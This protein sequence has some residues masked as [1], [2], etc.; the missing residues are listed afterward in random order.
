MNR[1]TVDLSDYPD[2]VVIYLGMR[3]NQFRGLATLL[4]FGPRIHAAVKSN[5]D[6][7]LAHENVVYSLFPLHVGMRQYWRD[8]E[9]LEAWARADPHRQWW[10]AFLRD[11]KGTG[12]WH[13]AYFRQGGMEAVYVNMPA[14]TGLRRFASSVE[15]RGPFFTS[16]QRAGRAETREGPPAVVPEEAL[17]EPKGDAAKGASR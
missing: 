1:T 16:R 5:P 11:P 12:F 7:L 4:G 10:Q 17:Y 9:S 14:R 2:L 15:A 6:G 3:V 13:E 8:F